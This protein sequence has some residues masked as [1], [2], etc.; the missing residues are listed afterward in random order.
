VAQRPCVFEENTA[1]ERDEEKYTAEI[2][3]TTIRNECRSQWGI[4]WLIAN[5]D[6]IVAWV[7]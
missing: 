2:R 6:I 1:L 4:A 7:K 3:R 5:F